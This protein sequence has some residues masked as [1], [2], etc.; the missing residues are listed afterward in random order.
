MTPNGTLAYLVLDYVT[1]HPELLDSSTWCG[2]ACCFAGHT[3]AL[4]GGRIQAE[5]VE[6]SSLPA[7]AVARIRDE[8]PGWA[9][10]ADDR[11]TSVRAAAKAALGLTN[12]QATNLFWGNNTLSTLTDL[13]ASL[14][15]PRPAPVTDDDEWAALGEAMGPGQ[16]GTATTPESG[17]TR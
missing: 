8:R 11:P 17:A 6:L 15:G 5:S 4:I 14:F 3:V 2:T 9:D 13:V 16:D 7:E 12:W 10:L 1:A